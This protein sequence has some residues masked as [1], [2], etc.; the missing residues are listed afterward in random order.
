MRERLTT[1][2]LFICAWTGRAAIALS[3]GRHLSVLD[4]SFLHL[5]WLKKTQRALHSM[6][7]YY[8][9]IEKRIK[10]PD[11]VLMAAAAQS[12][13]TISPFRGGARTISS[14]SNPE[15]RE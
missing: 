9:L 14:R 1:F 6:M 15:V 5:L 2:S 4:N 13:A 10:T 11:S 8:S 7:M 3:T 12:T